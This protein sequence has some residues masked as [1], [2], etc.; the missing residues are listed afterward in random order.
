M[1]VKIINVKSKTGVDTLEAWQY[2]PNSRDM[3]DGFRAQTTSQGPRA[4]LPRS[5]GMHW[6][7]A[8]FDW[9]LRAPQGEW[10][11]IPAPAFDD[12]FEEA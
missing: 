2:D 11:A 4:V 9:A 12:L 10:I 6:T 3:P 8:A 1:S 5:D 7:M